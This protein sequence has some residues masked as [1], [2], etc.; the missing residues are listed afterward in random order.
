MSKGVDSC[1]EHL[2]LAAPL[3]RL[4]P[5]IGPSRALR[6][7]LALDRLR[8]VLAGRRLVN[9][10]GDDRSKGGVYEI[11]RSTLPYFVGAGIDVSWIDVPT[12]VEVRQSL[13]WAHALGHGRSPQGSWSASLD[14]HRRRINEFVGGGAT[15]VAEYLRHDDVAILHDTQTALFAPV[16]RQNAG[17]V[18]WHAHIGSLTQNEALSAYWGLF[19]SSLE[20]AHAC[21][22][23]L[24]S[25]IPQPLAPKSV[26]IS[27]SIDPSAE[28]H[29]PLDPS[30]ARKI[31]VSPWTSGILHR[32]TGRLD[33]FQDSSVVAVQVSRWDP[34]KRMGEVV[35][36]FGHAAAALP[37]FDGAVVGTLAQSASEHRELDF[38]LQAHSQ[39]DPIVGDRVHIWLVDRSGSP[40][41]DE[42][43][44]AV[45][46]A[47]DIIIQNSLEE[48]FGL[49]VTE[50]MLKGKPVIARDVGGIHV[51]IE[52]RRTGVLLPTTAD[53][54]DLAAS[55][56][57]LAGDPSLRAHLGEEAK[58]EVLRHY[59]TDR[60]LRYIS[61]HLVDL[62][63]P[64]N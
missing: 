5:Y 43:I 23:Y 54:S 64:E 12:P 59:V 18:V 58:R 19:E 32:H 34:L 15:K 28:K 26:A 31:L 1:Q 13:E 30:S 11:L 61:R 4:E 16:A 45:Q 3:A 8:S 29:R 41:H 51:Q 60:H 44:G 46:S 38:A 37:D 40:A 39:L 7:T 24:R 48:G 6:A 21:V 62:L 14:E 35:A 9:I 47:A 17:T 57:E 49:S 52:N 10:T 53:V 55:V 56:I 2:V 50:G 36:A 63:E 25:Y 42:V 27:P 20:G 33:Q 22:F